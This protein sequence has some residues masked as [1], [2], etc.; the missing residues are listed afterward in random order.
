MVRCNRRSANLETEA[1]EGAGSVGAILCSR[2]H[3]T[4]CLGAEMP[5]IHHLSPDGTLQSFNVSH[6]ADKVLPEP[7]IVITP[8]TGESIGDGQRNL[9]QNILFQ[10]ASQNLLRLMW[11]PLKDK[12]LVSAKRSSA[13]SAPEPDGRLP[14]VLLSIYVVVSLSLSLFKEFGTTCS[15]GNHR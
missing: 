10:R 13:H 15:S 5:P 3:L 9:G 8:P 7:N 11:L 2:T 4:H 1:L 12:V 6:A 14:Q